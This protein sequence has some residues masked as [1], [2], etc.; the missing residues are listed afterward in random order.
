MGEGFF[1]P[2]FYFVFQNAIIRQ[3]ADKEKENG[4]EA[5]ETQ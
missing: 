3:N 4:R 5:F 1:L 2:R